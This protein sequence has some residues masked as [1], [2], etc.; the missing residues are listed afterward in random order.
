MLSIG[1][2][3]HNIPLGMVITS[4]FYKNNNNKLVTTL[5]LFGLSISTFLGGL[6]GYFI[7]FS[8]GSAMGI[9]YAITIGMLVYI[10]VCEL[11]PKI[12]E[13]KNKLLCLI[14]FLLGIGLLI[15][16]TMFE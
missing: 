9:I 13:S 5:I 6:I 4:S 2:G 7:G 14:G 10:L 15:I 16:S 8:E 3:L 1:V 12:F 11:L